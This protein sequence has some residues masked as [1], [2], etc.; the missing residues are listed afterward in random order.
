MGGEVSL[1]LS[2]GQGGDLG[3][4]VC[5]D[6]M[7]GPDPGSFGGVD[8]GAVPAV[9]AF[10][11]TDP[12]L[13][14][15]SPFH[16]S[17]EGWSSFDGL[18]SLRRSAL[19]GDHDVPDAEVVEILIDGGFAV[20]AVSGHRPWLP[21]GPFDDSFDR[22]GQSWGVGRVAG[23]DVVVEHDAVLVVTDLGQGGRTR[24]VSRAGL[25]RSAGRPGR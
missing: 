25:S 16:G 12:T 4:V 1:R 20:T 5:E 11:V 17:S 7:S 14:A 2:G 8:H 18:S 23:E 9:V 6:S 13:A 22:G 24:P 15:G 21:A 3:E 10:E 19:A